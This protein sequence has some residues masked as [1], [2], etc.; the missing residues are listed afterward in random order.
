M[1]IDDEIESNAA[2]A[3]DSRS[4]ETEALL[5]AA[6]DD[7][8]LRVSQLDANELDESL[9]QMLTSKLTCA[10]G[11]F[12]VSRKRVLGGKI[13]VVLTHP[14]FDNSLRQSHGIRQRFCCCSS[15]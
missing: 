14:G 13:V 12:S 4:G 5:T 7:R 2:T 6:E 11:E 3:G 15:S 10:L 8:A 9:V 1:S